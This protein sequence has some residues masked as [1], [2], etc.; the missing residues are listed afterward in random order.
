MDMAFSEI[1]L[2]QHLHNSAIEWETAYQRWTTSEFN[3]LSVSELTDLTVKIIKN[4]MQFEKYLPENN[5]VPAL[6]AAADEFKLKLPVI[7][8]LRNPNFRPVCK[9][10]YYTH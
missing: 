8:Y 1:R 2:R 5:I 4:C 9:Y 10:F 6:K 3:T 7:G